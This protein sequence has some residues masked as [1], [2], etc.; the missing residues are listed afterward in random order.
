MPLSLP[1]RD[2]HRL[3]ATVRPTPLRSV[4]ARGE[5]AIHAHGQVLVKNHCHVARTDLH[6]TFCPCRNSGKLHTESVVEFLNRAVISSRQ[7]QRVRQWLT[8]GRYP[9]RPPLRNSEFHKGKGGKRENEDRNHVLLDVSFSRFS[10]L[11]YGTRVP[12]G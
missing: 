6:F 11:S 3:Q 7:L 10:N 8:G 9:N 4:G 1:A 12:A 2:S 5:L